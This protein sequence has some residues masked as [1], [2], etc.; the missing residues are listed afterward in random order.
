M[1]RR[2]QLCWRTSKESRKTCEKE[3]CRRAKF[4]YEN[5]NRAIKETLHNEVFGQSVDGRGMEKF[6]F[7]I[8]GATGLVEATIF[9]LGQIKLSRL[10][11]SALQDGWIRYKRGNRSW[12]TTM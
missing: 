1:K 11:Q 4:W 2:Q 5:G 3:R 10:A 7:V 6:R 12:E 9:G 8:L